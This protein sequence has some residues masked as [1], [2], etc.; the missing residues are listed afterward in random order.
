[1]FED[2]RGIPRQAMFLIY[3]GIFPALAY[4]MV[5]TDLSYYLTSVQGIS[6]LV[7]GTVVAI[8]GLSMVLSSIPMGIV[9]D[10]FGRKRVI[11]LG[12]I[13]AS[14]VIAIF[15]LT[16]N[17]ALLLT[18]AFFEGVSEA[19]FSSSSSALLADLSGDYKRT[20]AFT[21]YGFLTGI[22]SGI[23]SF[24]IPL[25]SIF[26]AFGFSSKQ[27]H[28]FLYV[29][30]AI[31]SLLSTLLVLKIDRKPLPQGRSMKNFF[32]KKSRNVLIKYIVANSI[33]ALGAGFFVPIMAR[34]FNLVYGISD[35]ISGP[36]LG[37]S[38]IL[39]G[40]SSL[41]APSL[42]RRMGMVKA[43]VVTQGV[44]TVF[45]FAVPLS[46]T[47]AV[48][49]IMYTIRSF[50]M[51]MAG[52]LQQ[53]MIMGLVSPDERGAASGVSAALWRLPNSFS[54]QV[55][56]WF[57]SEGL[58]TEPFFLATLLYAISIILFWAFFRKIRMP[59]EI[60]AENED[61]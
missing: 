24:V 50:L 48:A 29:M 42:A 27:G 57:L 25:V 39:I 26:E 51:N 53:S 5:Y 20:S 7:M 23:G 38:S 44:S 54:V 10:R 2:Y 36:V 55:G 33:I 59:E 19:A 41:A 47:F 22:A 58:L 46:P 32:P 37:V 35:S 21:F 28:T 45:M 52:P 61:R 11:I 6:D 1:L 31:V 13:V 43:I 17:V 12:N 18:A 49:S 30:V 60:S 8:M 3:A 16:T 56:T 15:A 14:S 34:W 4:G 40:V 9:A